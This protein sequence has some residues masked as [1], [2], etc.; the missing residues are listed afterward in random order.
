MSVTLFREEEE[1]QTFNFE[2]VGTSLQTTHQLKPRLSLILR[3][4]FSRT[5][6]SDVRVP[7]DEVDRQYRNARSSGPSLSLV[8]D[9]RD[10]P[11]DPRRG[12]FVAVDT[13]FSHAWL[14]GHSFFKSFVQA[15]AYKA[16]RG[17]LLLAGGLRLGT[18]WTFRGQDLDPP[19]R[20]YAGGDYS[21]RGFDTDAVAPEGGDSLWVGSVEL[22]CSLGKSFSLAAFGDVGN[23]YPTM[24]ATDLTDLRA[25]TGLGLRYRT[26]VGPIRFDW[27][28]NL[29]PRPGE[30]RSRPHI[31]VGHAF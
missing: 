5:R 17:R 30:P 25:S 26:P 12:R 1:R 24:A 15:S 3:Y 22:R 19:D 27:G 23:V 10:D 8:S 20:F 11:L 4:V 9:T 13:Q 29:H 14:G 18:A 16:V 7:L 31:T 6:S 28:F 2:R 21:M